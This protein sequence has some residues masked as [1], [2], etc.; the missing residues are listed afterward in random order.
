MK[1]T[2]L[3]LAAVLCTV[4]VTAQPKLQRDNIDEIL[5][6]LTLEEKATL[7]VGGG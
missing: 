1:K 3:I 4:C 7:L 2:L 6:A 5:K